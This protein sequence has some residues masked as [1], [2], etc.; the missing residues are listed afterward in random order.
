MLKVKKILILSLITLLFFGCS[1]TQNLESENKNNLNNQIKDNIDNNNINNNDNIEN[2]DKNTNQ[3]SENSITIVAF[4]D[5]LTQGLGVERTQA[6]PAQ[7]QTYLE[8]NNFENVKVINSGLS[9]ETSTGASE[10]VNWVLKL[11]PDVV[12]LEIGPNDG[13]RGIDIKIIEENINSII[14]TLKQNN[15]TIV[16]AGLE[17]VENLGQEYSTQF[18]QLYP[19]I[20]KEQN[21]ILIESFLGT[22]AGNLT[23][24]QDDR[25]HPTEQGYSVIVNQNV[26]PKIIETLNNLK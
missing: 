16:L 15:V 21:I 20:A 4:G 26:G 14:Q 25:I 5:S 11:N 2:K 1:N 19:K 17:I 6:Y 8:N 13:F 24:N 18:K 9:G 23:L 22:V 12:I 7:L 10:R 3:E